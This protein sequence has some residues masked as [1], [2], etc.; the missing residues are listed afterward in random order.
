MKDKEKSFLVIKLRLNRFTPNYRIKN[1]LF[2]LTSLLV[3]V[4]LT[5]ILPILLALILLLVLPYLIV[6][7][8]SLILI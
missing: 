1:I 6:V 2:N 4:N 3:L 8:L 7:L 5:K